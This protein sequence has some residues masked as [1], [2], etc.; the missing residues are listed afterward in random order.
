[1]HAAL[2][3]IA[4]RLAEATPAD[5]PFASHAE[6]NA[7]I[8]VEAVAVMHATGTLLAAAKDAESL[9]AIVGLLSALAST[10]E[11]LQSLIEREAL[12]A[13]LGGTD[14][15]AALLS[16]LGVTPE[17]LADAQAAGH[18]LDEGCPACAEFDP[19]H[20]GTND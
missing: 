8:G 18:T 15:D 11:S 10:A 19:T 17:M 5:N 20:D 1:M 12:L 13:A 14:E 2:T 6:V 4:A 16:L 9:S 3:D 7:A